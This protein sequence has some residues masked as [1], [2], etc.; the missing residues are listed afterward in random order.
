MPVTPF[1][2]KFDKFLNGVLNDV[3]AE[4]SKAFEDYIDR[5]KEEALQEG[6][7]NPIQYPDNEHFEMELSQLERLSFSVADNPFF[8]ADV[9]KYYPECHVVNAETGSLMSTINP[10]A[11]SSQQLA[12]LAFLDNFRDEKL[13]I[14]DD[15]KIKFELENL[16]GQGVMFFLTVKTFDTRGEKVKEGAYDQAWFRLQNEDT[17]QT[18]DYTKIN[19]IDIGETGYD[20]AQDVAP[21]EEEDQAEQ[22]ERNELIYLAG[23]I[24]LEA[25]QIKVKRPFSPHG[26]DQRASLDSQKKEGEEEKTGEDNQA[27]RTSLN[28]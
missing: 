11:K 23:R 17:N 5:Y 10:T 9:A 13:K 22:G 4:E 16:K 15:R 8:K 7:E 6:E 27:S 12:S 14:N 28:K 18:L 24:Y 2:K 21:E 3:E 19:D 26:T 20:P 25:P 1:T